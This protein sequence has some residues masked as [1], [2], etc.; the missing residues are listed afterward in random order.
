[1]HVNLFID[2]VLKRLQTDIIRVGPWVGGLQVSPSPSKYR[3]LR[4]A[5]TLFS[6]EIICSVAQKIAPMAIV[7][8]IENP[9][10][11]LW[12]F[13]LPLLKSCEKS[14]TEKLNYSY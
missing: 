5:S 3:S 12:V 8:Q 4:S 2:R 7:S 9:V 11:Y 13:V 6:T 1:M 10:A 14:L